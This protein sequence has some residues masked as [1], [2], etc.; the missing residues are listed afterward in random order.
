[1]RAVE[2]GLSL[3]NQLHKGR[4]QRMFQ[5]PVGE[6]DT[7]LNFVSFS[8]RISASFLQAGEFMSF[9]KKP[10]PPMSNTQ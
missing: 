8:L 1:M 3:G 7:D 2:N 4:F 5:P 9:E 10:L 6:K